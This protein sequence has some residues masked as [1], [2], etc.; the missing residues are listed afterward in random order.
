MDER[1]RVSYAGFT[2]AGTHGQTL[3]LRN[4]THVGTI[5]RHRGNPG[6]MPEPSLSVFRNIP[7]VV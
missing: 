2:G 7:H 6:G 1:G 3:L 4:A 5:H